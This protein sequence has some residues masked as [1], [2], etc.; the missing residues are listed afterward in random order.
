M[1]DNIVS[2]KML[3]NKTKKELIDLLGEPFTSSEYFGKK[4]LQFRTLQKSGQYL[5]WYLH[6]EL[7]NGIVTHAQKSLD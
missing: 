4:S 5:H 3:I 2:E 7:E 6:V 1:L